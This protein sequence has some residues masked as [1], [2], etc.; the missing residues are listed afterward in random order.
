MAEESQT[1]KFWD[2]N[3]VFGAENR[4][5]AG[6]QMIA[7]SVGRG[8]SYEQRR[9]LV[10]F[11]QLVLRADSFHHQLYSNMMGAGVTLEDIGG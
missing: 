7:P 8:Q 6:T 2:M 9:I 5:S 10:R 11:G 3:V 1:A 4:R